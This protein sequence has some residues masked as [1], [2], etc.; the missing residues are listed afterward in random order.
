MTGMISDKLKKLIQ[1]YKDDNESSDISGA[2]GTYN[3]SF[4]RKAAAEMHVHP[5]DE[6]IKAL[7]A[8]IQSESGGRN[9]MQQIH[10]VNSGGNEAAGIL[11]YTPGTF[12][13][14][15]MP[16]HHNRMNP[17]DELLAFF[18]NSD[19]QN[20][21]GWT[22]IWGVRKMDWLHSGPQ[23]HRRYGNGGVI[24]R[25]QMALIGEGNKTEF[26]VPNPSVAG[27]ARTYEMIGRA[28]AYASQ[29]TGGNGSVMSGNALK[30]VER[31]LDALIDYSATQLAELKKPSRSYVLQSD[32]YNGYNNQQKINDMRG[33]FVR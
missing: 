6:F 30:L 20:S 25:E 12:A 15:A 22:T 33:F 5:S 2:H 21:I 16:G 29:A 3:P 7:Q 28:A 14:F 31:K 17:F 11:Q 32:I 27:P 4:I 19:W 26:V 23:G 18:N 8:V 9:I 1:G 13:A 24:D 10:D